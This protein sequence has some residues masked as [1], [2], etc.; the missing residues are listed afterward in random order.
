[1]SGDEFV[2]L[3]EDL[4]EGR[5][6]HDI[7]R[8][9]AHALSEVFKVD[10]VEVHISASVGVAFGGY[11]AV[12]L[13]VPLAEVVLK[14]A[15]DAMFQAKRTGRRVAGRKV[16]E[17]LT[18]HHARWRAATAEILLSHLS[19]ET[20]DGSLG[21]IC[22]W[23]AE[24]S[25]AESA[26][27]MVREGDQARA[28]AW[29]GTNQGPLAVG[30]VGEITPILAG[31]LASGA[32]R[33]GPTG[34]AGGYAKAFPVSLPTD[35]GSRVRAGA[36]VIF[37]PDSAHL[38]RE[39]EEV[40]SSLA[41]QATL[42]FELAHV[43]SERDRLLPF[44]DPERAARDLHDLVIQRL[45]RAGLRLEATLHFIDNPA[46]AERVTSTV[47]ELKTTMEEIR[48]VIFALEPT[49]E[50]G[51]QLRVLEEVAGAAERLGF[52]PASS[53]HAAPGP[54]LDTHLQ[55]E[56]VAVL[57]EALS[58]AARHA[59][60]TRVKVRVIVDAELRVMVA[61]DGDGIG[62]P[63]RLSGIANARAR[64]ELLGGSLD[65]S[66]ATGGG[67]C[68]DWRVPLHRGPSE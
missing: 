40:L 32:P 59:Q 19:E 34:S 52:T 62:E 8:R 42:A 26:V 43:R 24:L 60:A 56:A 65:V 36:L 2:I 54:E 45:F 58:N 9:V 47:A 5:P 64:A 11:Q 41:M 61:D 35:K 48:K 12:G 31:A 55:L 14:Q 1:M 3:C 39:Q 23:T 28:V 38:G 29:G 53:F 10:E 37:G 13:R 50:V 57:R 30:Q 17:A 18:G 49:P 15:D 22:K 51:L 6:A 20:L 66:P 44:D 67:T 25:G 21:L 68:F 27:L 16:A 33:G 4:D 46:A 7:A 63:Q